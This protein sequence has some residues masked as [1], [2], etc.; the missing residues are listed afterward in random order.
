MSKKQKLKN[1]IEELQQ[2]NSELRSK[3]SHLEDVLWQSLGE[4]FEGL[5]LR[6]VRLNDVGKP[7]SQFSP[8]VVSGMLEEAQER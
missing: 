1:S 4:L 2:E 6:L 8:D 3:I 5:D 7:S